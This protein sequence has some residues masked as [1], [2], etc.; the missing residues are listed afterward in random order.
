MQVNGGGE[1]RRDGRLV[2]TKT[3]HDTEQVVSKYVTDFK[4][5]CQELAPSFLCVILRNVKIISA[6]TT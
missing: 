4:D 6:K 2:P 3:K 5:H 1:G